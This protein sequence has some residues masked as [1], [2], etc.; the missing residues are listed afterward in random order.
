MMEET[1]TTPRRRLHDS[2]GPAESDV[3]DGLHD[4]AG[5]LLPSS[6]AAADDWSDVR[7]SER[8]GRDRV[9][10]DE[11]ILQLLAK[12]DFQG[13]KRLFLHLCVLGGT[14]SFIHYCQALSFAPGA[15]GGHVVIFLWL[16]LLLAALFTHGF[17]LQCLGYC[18]QHECMHRSAFRTKW[19]ND[20]VG[21]LVSVSCFEFFCHEKLMHKQHHTFTGDVRRDP[22]ITSFWPDLGRSSDAPSASEDSTLETTFRKVPDSVFGRYGYFSE[23]FC[24][25]RTVY[26]HAMRLVNCA[27]GN[28]VDYSGVRWSLSD[29]EKHCVRSELRAAARLQ[30]G[31]YCSVFLIAA[32]T[33][34]F[35]NLLL[36]WV[37]PAVLGFAPI[38][39]VRNGEHADCALDH[40]QGL[41]N[42]RTTRSNFVIRHL[43]WNM[44]L[45]AEHHLYPMIPFYNLPKL[46]DFLDQH[47]EKKSK[48]FWEVNWRMVFEWIPKQQAM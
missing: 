20:W 39:F 17:V 41:R 48:G 7:H 4:G 36:Y 8:R 29:Q 21:F 19:L 37:L 26:S 2:S 44:N 40:K 28:P 22:E 13:C 30:L 43:M 45:H 14:G 31:L 12:S 3:L 27:R 25:H 18:C 11:V 6:D 32:T 46:R 47:L 1:S 5:L 35:G 34:S 10:A 16:P 15:A 42:T 33:S 23:F 38:H 9:L 24:L